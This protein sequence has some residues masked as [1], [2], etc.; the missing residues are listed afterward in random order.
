MKM[1]RSLDGPVPK[2][3]GTLLDDFLKRRMLPQDSPVKRDATYT[4]PPPSSPVRAT[5]ASGTSILPNLGL[6]NIIG[7]APAQYIG[8]VVNKATSWIP[9]NK[10]LVNMQVDEGS[11]S[12]KQRDMLYRAVEDKVKSTGKNSG[13]IGYEDIAALLPEDKRDELIKATKG[14]ISK[15]SSALKSMTNPAM[16]IALTLGNFSYRKDPET[17]QVNLYDEYDFL[18]SSNVEKGDDGKE[19]LKEGWVGDNVKNT[20][21]SSKEFFKTH[22]KFTNYDLWAKTNRNWGNR[23]ADINLTPKDTVDNSSKVSLAKFISM[24]K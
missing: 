8:Q 6:G 23:K 1:R 4:V 10:E 20:N 12:K 18:N 3:D 14:Q 22:D 2:R 13:V 15:S 16:D 19:K 11:F 21:E 17:G 5:G 9:G 7:N 24:I